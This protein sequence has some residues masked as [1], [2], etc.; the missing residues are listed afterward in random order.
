MDAADATGANGYPLALSALLG[1]DPSAPASQVRFDGIGVSDEAVEL[2]L[3]A[4]DRPLQQDA[5]F[6]LQGKA[7]LSDDW[8]DIADG[9]RQPGLW[10][11][12][13]SS[14]RFFRAVFRW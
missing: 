7:E 13:L 12:P 5:P 1:L 10:T 2:S 4:G 3:R 14:N 9:E 11:V 6:A 8:R